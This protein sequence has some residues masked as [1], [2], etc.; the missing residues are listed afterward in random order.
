MRKISARLLSLCALWLAAQQP[1][2]AQHTQR[3][4]GW[5]TAATAQELPAGFVAPPAG[6]GNVPFFWLNGDTLRRDRMSD[7]LDTLA[8]SATSGF[9]VSYIHKNANIDSVEHKSGYGMFGHTEP[10]EPKVFSPAWWEFWNWFSGACADRGMGLGLDDYTVGWYGNG[11]Y[12]DE[13]YNQPKYKNYQGKL[14]ITAHPVAAGATLTL[15]LPEHTVSVVALP[16]HNQKEKP[17]D[18]TATTGAG[19][20][21]WTAP[22]SAKSYTVYVTATQPDY[23]LHPDNGKELVKVYFDRFE[24]NMNQKGRD[25]MN[26][27][28]Q[29]ELLY[30]LTI[31]SWAED[32]PAQFRER[33]G[34]DILPYLAAL[35]YDIG[36]ITTKI[37]LDYCDV[38][39]TLAEERYFKPIFDWNDSR[40]LIYG[41]DNMGRGKQPLH[42]LDYFRATSWFTAPGNDAPA[43][44]S[45][46][47]QTKVSS[48]IA[49]LYERPRTWLEAFHSMGWGSK[50]EWLTEQIDHHF[51]AG[52]NL[53]C[54]HG[55]YYST[56]GGWW[57]WAP[58]CFH[59]HMPYWPHMKKWLE[60]TERVSYLMSQGHHVCDIA[61]LYPTETLQAFSPD[62]PYDD[63][64]N[65]SYIMEL[66]NAG[67]DYDLID[68]R[69]LVKADIKDKA[70][71]VSGESYKILLIKDIRALRYEAL[72]KL[73][74]FYRGGGIVLAIGDLPEASDRAGSNDPEVNKIVKEIFG[75][76][77]AQTETIAVKAQKN[78]TGGVGF[79]LNTTEDM[80][81]LIH[82]TITPDF[83]A[84]TKGGKVLHRRTDDRDV[85]MVMNVEPGTDCFFRAKGNAQLWNAFDG[86][87]QPLPVKRV[88]G[89]GTVIRLDTP[90]NRSSLVVFSPGEP[91]SDTV[92]QTEKPP[93]EI[94]PVEGEW[95]VEMLPTLDNKWG[96]FRLPATDEKIG[97]EARRFRFIPLRA[98]GKTKTWMQPAYNDSTWSVGTYGFGAQMEVLVDGSSQKADGLAAAVFNGTLA[99]WKPYSFSWQYGVENNPGSQGYHGL[100]GRVDNN[101]LILDKGR[102][103]LF[104]TQF[105][106]PETDFYV[107]ITGNVTPEGIYI[108][109]ENIR[110]E[111]IVSREGP[112][113]QR[114]T[115]YTVNLRKGWHSLLL[116]FTNTTDQ[117]LHQEP[118]DLLDRRTRSTAVILP[119][120]DTAVK[121]NTPYDDIVAMKWYRSNRLTFDPNAGRPQKT[122]YRFETVPGLSSLRLD[123]A[124]HLE[125]AWVD[126]MAI[127]AKTN[128][129][130]KG[131]GRYEIVLPVTFPRT[132]EMTLQI[133][134]DP[135]AG[136]TAV[137]REPVRFICSKGV[138]NAGD[139]S[140][141]GALLY[142]SGGMYYRKTVELNEQQIARGVTLDLGKVSASCEIK[143][144]GK[145]A[146]IH[147]YSPFS[148]DI[149]P[150]LHP[151]ENRIEVLVYST[152]ANHY[153]T[154]PT[155]YKGD[156]EAGLIG[157][158]RLIVGGK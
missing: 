25:G 100:K 39:M 75:M 150:Y 109:G 33:K 118:Y 11:Y 63:Q 145:D 44:G 46:F 3:F 96:D 101:F 78:P 85:Y 8:T 122:I 95:E 34:Y 48:S 93:Q 98:L 66:S 22:S 69:S 132:S 154:S 149:T 125:K 26:Y 70:L 142:Y 12:P 19:K 36:D 23:L 138:M 88:T 129:R 89:E 153:Q 80:V 107:L 86:T 99:D 135:G 82:R 120:A 121:E 57:E 97:P 5:P 13:V 35:K 20:L 117:P 51:L 15:T 72:L 133:T 119:L 90:Y 146:G 104:R 114:E 68:N 50:T 62:K 45:S 156:P 56:H 71:H 9:S 92:S 40:G 128:I 18:L 30:P 151:G 94:I 32:M 110:S 55:L 87:M 77:A 64:Y 152:L 137:F 31:L 106:A 148:A 2:A 155:P 4:N 7:I 143:V 24:Q 113:G 54:M 81:P 91:V 83:R 28:F 139:W 16:E 60:Y 42:Y 49:H 116:V 105:Y 102:N 127:N 6:Y 76:T 43:R 147:I 29:D 17:I 27:F 141:N 53:V 67:L 37:R 112:N 123:L 79:Y 108:D 38:V 61:I 103:M 65:F 84:G 157:P 47:I 111:D 59:Y 140:K 126:G 21:T 10:G 136:G 52:G 41:C 74:D 134:P 14:D 58:P 1:A 144:N 73:R 130:T 115:R 124:G 131:D 158:V